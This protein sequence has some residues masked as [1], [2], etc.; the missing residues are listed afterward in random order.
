MQRLYMLN[1]TR[2]VKELGYV[3]LDLD[4]ENMSIKISLAKT[5]QDP[6]SNEN[7]QKTIDLPEIEGEV[8]LRSLQRQATE[9]YNPDAIED[10]NVDALLPLFVQLQKL[11]A[12][13]SLSADIKEDSDR[14]DERIDSSILV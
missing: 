10:V 8:S 2:K 9:Y 4:L 11:I 3:G 7:S 13:S 12:L 5:S 14:F 6:N 1:K